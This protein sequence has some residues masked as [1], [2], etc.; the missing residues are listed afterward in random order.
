MR[1]A[2]PRNSLHNIHVGHTRMPGCSAAFVFVTASCVVFWSIVCT[3]A[4]G[5]HSRCA[6]DCSTL[7]ACRHL[8]QRQL[9]QQGHRFVR[10]LPQCVSCV[11]V[12]HLHHP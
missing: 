12:G 6:L 10:S 1:I 3:P 9:L 8:V 5:G 11:L 4:A 7:A 2:V